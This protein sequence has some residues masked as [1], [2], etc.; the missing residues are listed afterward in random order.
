MQFTLFQA[1]Q[2]LCTK[3]TAYRYLGRDPAPRPPD[4]PTVHVQGGG[5]PAPGQDRE[6]FKNCGS[7]TGWILLK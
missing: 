3:W 2:Q 5:V 1:L 4:P 7:P 6:C